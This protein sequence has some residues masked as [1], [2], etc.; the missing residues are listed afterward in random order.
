MKHILLLFLALFLSSSLSAQNTA[1]DDGGRWELGADFLPLLDTSY[2]LKTSLLA[3]YRLNDKI[4]LR[5]R[6]GINFE[7]LRNRPILFPETH[8]LGGDVVRAYLSAGFERYIHNGRVSVYLGAEAFGYYYR[9]AYTNDT[10]NSEMANPAIVRYITDTYTDQR[11]GANI[12]AGFNFRIVKR[13]SVSVES[14]LHLAYRRERGYYEQLETHQ[15]IPSFI[16]GRII[17]RYIADIQPISALH[18]FYHF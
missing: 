4:K 12:L 8:L 9:D 5:S 15:R 1:T 13:L 10:D 18:L 3:R 16:G 14:F 17:K 11:Y 7:H 6:V 2:S